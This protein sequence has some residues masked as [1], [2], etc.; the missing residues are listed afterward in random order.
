MN[1]WLKASWR[2]EQDDM[3]TNY[4]L[5]QKPDCE[6][7]GRSFEPLHIG[8]S[9]GGWC[10]T[11]HVIPEDNINDLDDWRMLWAAPGAFIRN[12]YGEKMSIPEM[13]TII[14]ERSRQERPNWTPET[15]RENQAEP[16]VNNLA[17]HTIDGRHCIKHGAGTWDCIT[18]EFS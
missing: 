3:G 9:S 6:C 2:S 11:L 5:H 16:G 8:K 10:F 13:E 15:Y 4:Y 17:R 12:E 18:G 7:C 14:T 1:R